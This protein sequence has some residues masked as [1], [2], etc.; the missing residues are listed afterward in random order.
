MA[1]RSGLLR[2]IA[3]AQREAERKRIAQTRA[4]TQAAKTAA[5][6]QKAYQRAQIADQKERARLYAE[7]RAAQV[8]MQSDELESDIIRLNNLLLEA[9]SIDSFIDFHRLKET[10]NLPVFNPGN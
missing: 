2:A 3:Q 7:S 1:R 6:A 8:A 9:L 4:Q 5:Q 10:P